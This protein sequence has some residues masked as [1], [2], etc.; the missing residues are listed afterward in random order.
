MQVDVLTIF[1]EMFPGVLGASM[2][3]RARESGRVRVAVHD[4][5]DWSRDKH[6]TAHGKGDDEREYGFHIAEYPYG[7]A[8]ICHGSAKLEGRV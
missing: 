3:K 5:R 1:P 6:R 8:M 2:L 4:L 7:L